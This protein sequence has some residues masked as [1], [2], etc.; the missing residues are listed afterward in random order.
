[1]A[2]Q[3]CTTAGVNAHRPDWD[4]RGLVIWPRGGQRLRLSHSLH[5]PAGW[6]ERNSSETIRLALRWWAEAAECR[7]N[8]NTVHQG[9]L[10]DTACRWPLPERFGPGEMLELELL[11]QSPRHDD[12]ALLLAQLEREPGDPSDPDGLLLASQLRLLQQDLPAGDNELEACCRGIPTTGL[13]SP[14]CATG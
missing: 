2:R 11:L 14:T 1:M 12:G 13:R 7:I 6:G 10:F 3:P 8:G 5:W 4:A 9:D